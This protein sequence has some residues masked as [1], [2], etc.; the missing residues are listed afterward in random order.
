MINTLEIFD[1]DVNFNTDEKL[2]K[3]SESSYT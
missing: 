2:I 3:I 1:E